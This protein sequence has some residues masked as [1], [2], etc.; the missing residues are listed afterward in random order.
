MASYVSVVNLAA[1]LIGTESRITSPSDDKV[2]ARRAAAVWDSQRRAA[3]RDGA[4]NFA[5]RRVE[6]PEIVGDVA[7]PWSA[8][9]RMPSDALRL[10]EVLS[11]SA[12]T[13]YQVEGG[14]VL[15][16]VEGPLRIRYL[17]DIVQP[18][19]W[20]DSFVDAFAARIAW[21]IGKA[22]AGS[23]YDERAGEA[24]YRRILADAKRVD[25]L[26]NPPV[27]QAEDDWIV[28]RHGNVA[29]SDPLRW[30]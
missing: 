7:Y 13:D 8:A 25:A 19:L 18:E 11:P 27:D 30:G 21:K 24:E 28:A 15:C 17:V 22:I 23:S 4:W 3:I 20:D 16:H 26:E 5:T 10:I 1:A 29:G 14:K 12:G 2:L 6:L 9:Y